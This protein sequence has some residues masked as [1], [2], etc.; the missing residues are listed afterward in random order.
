MKT[1]T[2]ERNV[3]TNAAERSEFTATNTAKIFHMLISGLYSNKPQSITREIWTNA[4][5][6][7]VD[8]GTPDRPFDVTFPSLF[9]PTFTVRDYG[10]SMPHEMIMKRY[11][12]LGDSTK[13]DSNDGVGKWG[14]GSKSPFSYTDTFSVTAYLDGEARHYSAVIEQGGIPAM[15]CL[16]TVPTDEPN[17]IEISFPVNTNDVRSFRKAAQRVSYGFDVKPNVVGLDDGEE[18][19]G[20]VNPPVLHEGKGWKLLNGALEGY[21]GTAYAK[22]GCVLYPIDVESIDGLTEEQRQM[23]N[24]TLIIEFP[25]GSLEITPSR[26][27]L[28]YGPSDPT[29]ETI[30]ARTATIFEEVAQQVVEDYASAP[31]YWDACKLFV[32][33][34]NGGLPAIVVKIIREKAVWRGMKLAAEI[35]LR[36]KNQRSAHHVLDFCEISGKK[37]GNMTVKFE[38]GQTS[39]DVQPN[40]NTVVFIENMSLRGKEK[41]K[42]VAPRIKRYMDANNAVT[43]QFVW[44]KYHDSKQES[45]HLIWLLERMDGAEVIDVADIDAPEIYRTPSESRPVPVRI[46]REHNSWK[47]Y[48]QTTDLTPEEMEEGGYYVKLERME[49]A[50]PGNYMNP[51][52]M[53]PLLKKVGAI[54]KDTTVFAV[55]KTLWKK[56]SGDQWVELHTVAD[57]YVEEHACADTLHLARAVDHGLGNF[58]LQFADKQIDITKLSDKS[59]MVPA[60]KFF[61]GLHE[62]DTSEADRMREVISAVGKEAT[63]RIDEKAQLEVELEYHAELIAE[64]YPLLEM[65]ARQCSYENDLVDKITQYIYMCD[66]AQEN[67]RPETAVAA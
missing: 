40:K 52:S 60:I 48:D 18:F 19:E 23:L 1:E 43:T 50:Q 45:A 31:T 41:V 17:G 47:P 27:S 22:M 66:V 6:A 5:D 30:R 13:E 65:M 11:T 28:Q 59:D 12:N 46:V 8:A 53:V 61:K 67:Q 62:V 32:K 21:G 38:Y 29:S 20:W 24:A 57:D 54:P 34:I 10:T 14:I 26:E 42:R 9:N 15:Y 64:V 49:C 36:P 7:H 58:L 25:I 44:V 37:L 39:T 56:F 16:A 2:I 55:S 63:Y 3:T 35:S 33:H 4:L 51:S